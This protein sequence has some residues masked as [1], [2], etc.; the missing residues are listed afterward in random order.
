VQKRPIINR[1]A[2]G[3]P[4]SLIE[5]VE[6]AV[7]NELKISSS[8]H[9]SAMRDLR[10]TAEQDLVSLIFRTVAGN[11]ERGDA[12]ANRNRSKENW[13]WQR[14]QP[15]I[16]VHNAS[17]E[18][19]LERRIAA[20]CARTG[21]TDWANQI[22]VASGLIAGAADGRRAIDLVHR[23][24]ERHFEAIELKIASDT[25]LYAAVEIIS[26]GCIWLF[27]R[28]NPPS[29]K[30]AILEADRIDLRV[31][32]PVNYYACY[33]LTEL[34]AA[35]DRGCRALGEAQGVTITFAFDALDDRLLGP[36]TLNDK[37]LL[38]ALDNRVSWRI[39]RK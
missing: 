38:T 12:A 2:S 28:A 35:V 16:A 32:A 37:A 5:G 17:A 9:R 11:Y 26:Y 24:G 8:R 31:L 36:V 30:S 39:G 20:P 33:D 25:P 19:V 15:Q 22:P 7:R 34:E 27:A 21:R 13:R 29:L 3:A 4:R 23:S 6:E 1:T 14:L 18:V 10:L